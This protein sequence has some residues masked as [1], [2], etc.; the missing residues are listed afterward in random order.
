MTVTVRF[1]PSPTGLLHIGNARTALI[2]WLF[3]RARHGRFILRIDDT[4]PDRCRPEFIAAIEEDLRWLG[5]IWDER[6]QQ[7]TRLAHYRLAFDTLQHAGRLYPCYETPEELEAK[8]RARRARGEPPIYDR[9]GRHLDE[10]HRRLY[11]SEG[12]VPHWRFALDDGEVAWHDLIQGDKRFLGTH[13][14]DPVVLRADGLPTYIF[15]SVV[16][17]VELGIT[18]VIR[19]EDHVANTAV[20]VQIIQ[21]LGSRVPQFAHLPLLVDAEGRSLS[22]RLGGLTLRSLREQGIEPM[23]I[24]C[25]LAA[26]GTPDAPRIAFEPQ[27]L[28]TE[29]ALERFGRAPPKFDPAML[30]RINAELL[31]AM[32]YELARPRLVELGLGDADARFWHAVRPNLTR[33]TEAREWW[34]VITGPITPVIED[35][36]HLAVAAEL[37]PE[38]ELDE[39]TFERW[40]TAIKESTGRRGRALYRP[41]RLALTGREHG[42]ELRH[43]LPLIGRQRAL[44]RLRGEVA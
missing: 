16:D 19:G 13:L 39:R 14:S 35:R 30:E 32:P 22:K 23:A 3:A 37:L 7:S 43:L 8:R 31:H 34:A 20:Q 40:I 36:G 28:A 1:A 9:A 29:F 17:D 4:D 41:L 26:L 25:L 18:H 11:E 2:N 44:A 10:A 6:H 12:R 24:N 27:D 21:A 33:L 38:G 15:A 5:L 42:P